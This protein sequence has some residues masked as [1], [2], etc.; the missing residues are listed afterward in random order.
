MSSFHGVERRRGVWNY[1]AAGSD[2]H[3]LIVNTSL[4]VSFPFASLI[5]QR[6]LTVH[7][8][9]VLTSILMRFFMFCSF[10]R[11]RFRCADDFGIFHPS[12]ALYHTFPGGAS[13]KLMNLRKSKIFLRINTKISRNGRW[14]IFRGPFGKGENPHQPKLRSVGGSETMVSHDPS[15]THTDRSFTPQAAIRS[16]ACH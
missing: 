5:T 4:I 7:H 14:S 11:L 1:S 16:P 15:G 2:Y 10:P 12:P 13:L 9:E 3:S 8:A 6:K